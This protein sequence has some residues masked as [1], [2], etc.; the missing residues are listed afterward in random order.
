MWMQDKMLLQEELAE[1]ICNLID[2]YPTEEQAI[3]FVKSLIFS[4]SKE[5]PLIDRWRMDKFLMVVYF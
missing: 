1:N 4:L 3:E 5:W 2:L